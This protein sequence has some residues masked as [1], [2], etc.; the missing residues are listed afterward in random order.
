MEFLKPE[1]VL[2][3]RIPELDRFTLEYFLFSQVYILE[4]QNPSHESISD[5]GNKNICFLF[6]NFVTIRRTV[7]FSMQRGSKSRG[8]VFNEAGP[9]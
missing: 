4:K 1:K 8:K 3:L 7:L 6:Y 5:F 9:V 2:S